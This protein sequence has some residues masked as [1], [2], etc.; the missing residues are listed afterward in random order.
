MDHKV[1]T[2]FG[3]RAILAF[4]FLGMLVF[5]AYSNTFDSSWH[6]DDFPTLVD[7]SALHLEDLSAGSIGAT[8]YS[9]P[10]SLGKAYRP[11]SCLSLALNW[12][13]GGRQV[14]GYHLVNISIHLLTAFFLYLTLYNLLQSPRLA[15]KN[16][17]QAFYVALLSAAFW[18]LNPVQT[19]AV[20]YIVQ[21][22]A[23][24]AAMF[25]IL[26][27][28]CYVKGRVRPVGWQRNL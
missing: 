7:N 1:Y 26:G 16:R 18:A 8:F 4:G 12:Y 15:V 28:Y 11:V 25:Y 9:R 14:T 5:G 3:K 19:Q 20:T 17:E 22:M 2:S 21:R 24:L 27:L 6:L 10:G 23:S 13:F